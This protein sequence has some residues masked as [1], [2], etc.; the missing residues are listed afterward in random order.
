MT[1]HIQKFLKEET[2]NVTIDWVVLVSGIV[3]LAFAL[4]ITVTAGANDLNDKTAEAINS[5]EV[6]D[7]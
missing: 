1:K 3:G 5:I 2:G 7:S 4:V 6:G